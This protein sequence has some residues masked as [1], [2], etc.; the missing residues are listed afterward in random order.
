MNE[1][2]LAWIRMDGVIVFRTEADMK[3]VLRRA[4]SNIS[5]RRIPHLDPPKDLQL[6]EELKAELTEYP[7]YETN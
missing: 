2:L 7:P 5:Y 1:P 4:S 3:A 6:G